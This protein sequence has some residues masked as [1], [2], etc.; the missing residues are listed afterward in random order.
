[1]AIR[2]EMVAS[3]ALR[4]RDLCPL[5]LRLAALGLPSLGRAESHALITIDA[6]LGVLHRLAQRARQPVL[7]ENSIIDSAHSERLLSEHADACWGLRP[8]AAMSGSWSPW[9]ARQRTITS[10]YSLCRRGDVRGQAEWQRPLPVFNLVRHA[11]VSGNFR[12]WSGSASP[13]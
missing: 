3:L 7:T 5:L 1:M 4:R 8:L 11:R 13:C 6:V 2:A 12:L 9:R 10:R